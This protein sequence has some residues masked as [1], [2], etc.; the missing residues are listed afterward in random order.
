MANPDIS[1]TVLSQALDQA[2]A[3]SQQA[4]V[5]AEERDQEIAALRRDLADM[6]QQRD[7]LRAQVSEAG[8]FED[9]RKRLKDSVADALAAERTRYE[10]RTKVLRAAKRELN[11]ETDE[12]EASTSRKRGHYVVDSGRTL[13]SSPTDTNTIPPR[14]KTTVIRK[15]MYR[16]R[17]QKLV[18]T[19]HHRL[20]VPSPAALA[21]LAPGQHLR[22]SV[23]GLTQRMTGVSCGG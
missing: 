12:A 17:G 15:S 7:M 13:D 22:F 1:L 10:E 23:S 6:T 14:P 5:H 16:P 20:T 8:K 21:E 19:S 4:R 9:V 11:G 3:A 2:A 18:P